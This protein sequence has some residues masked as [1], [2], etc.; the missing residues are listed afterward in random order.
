MI[1]LISIILSFLFVLYFTTMSPDS[2]LSKQ[3]IDRIYENS[4]IKKILDVEHY[5]GEKSYRVIEAETANQSGYFFVP[6][7]TSEEIIFVNKE[8]GITRQN[9]KEIILKEKKDIEILDIRLAID[10]KKPLWE[11][12]FKEKNGQRTFFYITYKSGEFYKRLTISN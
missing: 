3:A 4:K 6:D 2:K 9:A 1:I 8:E 5:H 12:V 10:R 7:E 11:I